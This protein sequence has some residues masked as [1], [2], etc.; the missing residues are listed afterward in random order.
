MHLIGMFG[1]TLDHYP[2]LGPNPGMLP[3]LGHNA[4]FYESLTQLTDHGPRTRR[5]ARLSR[6]NSLVSA[7]RRLPAVRGDDGFFQP[8]TFDR[9]D[10]ADDRGCGAR[11]G[12]DLGLLR[13]RR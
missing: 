3:Y 13:S 1:A 8:R 2:A 12:R 11:A 10:Q 4:L 5:R 9:H 7:V 6:R